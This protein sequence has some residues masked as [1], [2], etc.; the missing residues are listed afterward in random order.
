MA[1]L[2]FMFIQPHKNRIKKT[3][4]LPQSGSNEIINTSHSHTAPSLEKSKSYGSQ[5]IMTKKC[6]FFKMFSCKTSKTEKC[7][8]FN[9][10]V[11]NPTSQNN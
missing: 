8:K 5:N 4:K 1:E 9:I 7:C 2:H 10:A 6:R 3:L 11:T